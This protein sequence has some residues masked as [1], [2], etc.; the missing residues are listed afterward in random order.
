MAHVWISFSVDG[1][2]CIGDFVSKMMIISCVQF[3]LEYSNCTCANEF[4]MVHVFLR[5]SDVFDKCCWCDFLI[6][7][8]H[9][10]DFDVIM[11]I[12]V[13]DNYYRS[14]T[15]VAFDSDAY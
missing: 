3:G 8:S 13:I 9:W 14:N 12:D 11:T 4:F 1:D 6:D 15:D 10:C 7:E 2:G 5:P